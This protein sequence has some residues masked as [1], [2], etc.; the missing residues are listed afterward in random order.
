MKICP[1]M[2]WLDNSSPSACSALRISVLEK[3][4]VDFSGT[5]EHL[6][7]DEHSVACKHGWSVGQR[8]GLECRPVGREPPGFQETVGLVN[9]SGSW[10]VALT[11]KELSHA[12]ERRIEAN[13]SCCGWL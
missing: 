2:S 10:N 4:L 5:V 12:C 11:S 9:P 6:S 1:P 3:L 8:I 7:C 13:V